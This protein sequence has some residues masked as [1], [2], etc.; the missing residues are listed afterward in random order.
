MSI[1]DVLREVGTSK[2][3]FYHYFGSKQALSGGGRAARGRGDCH[4]PDPRRR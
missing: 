4:R 1:Q 2:G 3:A